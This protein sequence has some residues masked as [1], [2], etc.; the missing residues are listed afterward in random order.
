MT[1]VTALEDIV[2]DEPIPRETLRSTETGFV[3]A[4][5]ANHCQWQGLFPDVDVAEAA[6]NTHIYR[7]RCRRDAYHTG[8]TGAFLTEL[9]DDGTARSTLDSHHVYAWDSGPEDPISFDPVDLG[10]EFP[11]ATDDVDGL[12]Q[13][14]DRIKLPG[15]RYGKVASVSETR[16]SGIATWSVRYADPDKDL[17]RDD[18]QPKFQ[19][20]LIAQ[21]G[22]VYCRYGERFLGPPVFEVV[23]RSDHQ[24][25]FSE[26]EGGASA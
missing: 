17:T 15:D 24:A 20:E 5:R 13:R 18:W 12:V 26:F 2:V 16:C 6:V 25:D 7:K 3:V 1:N 10:P 23:G 22:E 9:V 11:R 14:G 4:C 8:S 19:N 21:D